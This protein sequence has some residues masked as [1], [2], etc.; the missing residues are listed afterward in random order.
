MTKIS[1]SML[2]QCRRLRAKLS[3][4]ENMMI[5]RSQLDP[6]RAAA[7]ISAAIDRQIK[8]D[9]KSEQKYIKLLLLGPGEAGKST[10]IRQMQLIH[11]EALDI[12]EKKARIPYIRQNIFDS[13]VA[14]L[15]AMKQFSIPL[16]STEMRDRAERILQHSQVSNP[17][18]SSKDILRSPFL[19][20]PE[21]FEDVES[22]WKDEGVR[23]AYSRSNEYQLLD[24]AAYFFD[25]IG[26]IKDIDYIPSE[27]DIL[28]CR[29]MTTSI[30]ET[31]ITAPYE[32]RSNVHFKVLD[33]GG[34]QGERR[35]WITLFE[36]VTAV[37]FVQDI[38]S[39][40]QT[41]REDSQTNR[42]LESLKVFHQVIT[43][44]YLRSVSVLTFLNKIDILKEKIRRGADFG[45]AMDKIREEAY[46]NATKPSHTAHDRKIYRSL[47]DILAENPYQ[48]FHINDG[49]R[50]N[51][52]D[53]FPVPNHNQTLFT[54]PRKLSK[55]G[56]KTSNPT[57]IYCEMDEKVVK[58]ATY[59]RFLL[60]QI[61]DKVQDMRRKQIN[62]ERIPSFSCIEPAYR[63]YEFH[64]TCAI[65]K[66]NVAK[67]IEGC[68]SIII[69]EFLMRIGLPM[70]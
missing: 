9:G 70:G 23:Q 64:Y 21:F 30:T 36:K 61:I 2:K 11:G 35:K 57:L 42:L 49:D 38:S 17:T 27:Q 32:S 25:R 33:V 51:F 69:K 47:Y 68:K 65:D 54:L 4:S 45:A 3:G 19:S 48:N 53:A 58:A 34:Q 62:E 13:M 40:D 20:S 7:K 31:N 5:D 15:V 29:V 16:T 67:V 41:L 46:L 26:T 14:I 10:L 18:L 66:S 50:K 24:C 52:S 44:R 37:L 8:S 63:S 43:T 28:R 59:I 55:L 6:S 1:H 39:F 60:K 12:E 22:L 56:K